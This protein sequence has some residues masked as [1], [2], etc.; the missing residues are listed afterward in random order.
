MELTFVS[1]KLAKL[2]EEIGFD[3]CTGSDCWIK[4][5][6]GKLMHNSE[7]DQN[8][9][10]HDR[11]SDYLAQPTLELAK[12]WLRD[13]HCIIIET[14][15]DT[16]SFGYRVFNPYKEQNYFSDWIWKEL[17]GGWKY[18]EALEEG[19]KDACKLIKDEKEKVAKADNQDA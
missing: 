2:L 1:Y 9:C 10:L 19:V 6:D 8:N 15:F 17:N 18:E 11:T 5:L 12:M 14:C 13:K 4:T 16:I 3:L 7:R